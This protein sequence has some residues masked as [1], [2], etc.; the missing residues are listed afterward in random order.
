MSRGTM[1]ARMF[2]DSAGVS[3]E[4]FEV[5]RSGRDSGG[6]S[7]GLEGGWLAF[8]SAAGKRRLAPFP[9][10]WESASA[11]ELE[12]LCGTARPAVPTAYPKRAPR[13]VRSSGEHRASAEESSAVHNAVRAFAREARARRV[14]AI[15]AMVKLRMHLSERFAGPDVPPDARAEIEDRKR[16]RQWFV[17]AFY[18]ERPD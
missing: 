6:V 16:I 15:E 9:S 2:E 14:P 8:T 10:E 12:L 5:R 1:A 13:I 3:W 7:Q 18:F 4:V 17:D 11:S